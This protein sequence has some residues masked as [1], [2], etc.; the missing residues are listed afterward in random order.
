MIILLGLPKSGTSS[1]QSLFLKLNYNSYHWVK[2]KKYIGTMIKINKLLKKPLLSD[3][4]KN[5]VITQMDVCV[6]TKHCYWPQITDFKQIYNENKN[7][8]FILNKRDPV[9]VL[10]SFKKWNNYLNRLFKYN[11]ELIQDKTEKGFINFINEHNNKIE[12][13]FKNK[14]KAKF[15]SFDIENDSLD[16]L[17]KY[18]DIKNIINL[19]ISNTFEKSKLNKANKKSDKPI[20]DIESDK[21]IED[22]E[23]DKPI[24]DNE[25]D[26][27]VEDI[28][29]DKPIEDNES[30]KHGEDNESIKPVED[31]ESDKP[32]EDNESDKP[33]EDNE[34]DK[35]VEDIESD[36]PIED[37]ESIKHGE[38]NES[39]KPVEDNESIKPVEDNESDKPVEDNESDKPVE[40]IESDK[41]IEDNESDKPIEDIESDKHGEDN[42]SD[43]PIDSKD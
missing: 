13:F 6:N 37:N 16:K 41:P 23:S 11:P 18:I 39:I 35:P 19:P 38:D 22:N 17:K 42:E 20:E 27:P 10:K 36:K 1:F 31:N 12:N 30:D 4:K 8:V 29:S 21:P 33:I 34:S 9:K 24:E 32:I 14:K 7:A 25:S 15:I 5:D 43:K 26:K 2:D 3:F 28:E 40:D